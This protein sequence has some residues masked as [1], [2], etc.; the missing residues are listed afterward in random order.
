MQELWL[1]DLFGDSKVG[2]IGGTPA[3]FQTLAGRKEDGSDVHSMTAKLLGVTRD[4]AKISVYSRRYG[5]GLTAMTNY[6]RQFRKSLTSS[7]AKQIATEMFTKTKGKKIEGQWKLGSES[8]MFNEMERVATSSDPRTPAL[9][10]T[11]S[12][13]LHPRYTGNRDFMTSKINW[14]CQSSGVDFMH[15]CLTATSYLCREYKINARL[16]ITIH[17]EY[18]YIVKKED[19]ARFCLAFQIAHLWTRAMF[20]YSVGIYDLPASVAWFS[21]VDIDFTIRKSPDSP[22]ITPS[23]PKGLPLGKLRTMPEILKA[24]GG[25]L[26]K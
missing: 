2:L 15:L 12:D 9:G 4:E 19:S 20:C 14:V 26:T 24:T 13:A 5:A 10:R 3:S 18:R 11:L 7:Q 16:C 21:G 8:A 23:Q 17:D 6:L 25:S 22:A 1:S